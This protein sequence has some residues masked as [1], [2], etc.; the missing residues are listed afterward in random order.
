MA[1]NVKNLIL[2]RYQPLRQA[3][4]GGFASVVVAFDT[5]IQRTVALK[6]IKLSASEEARAALPG[7]NAV[8]PDPDLNLPLRG[9]HIKQ[10]AAPL[11]GQG[12]SYRSPHRRPVSADK[13]PLTPDTVAWETADTVALEDI[14]P[15]EDEPQREQKPGADTSYDGVPTTA[16][17]RRLEPNSPALAHA[18]EA[19]MGAGSEDIESRPPLMTHLPGLD[20]ART[21]AML[22]DPSIVTVYDFEVRDGYAYLIMEYIEGLT[23]A[24]LLYS[25]HDEITLDM[26]T[27]VFQGVARALQVA[28]ERSVLHLDVKPDN[29]L[30]TKKGQVK[31]T[32]FGLATLADASGAANPGGGTIAY[33]P[34]EQLQRQPVDARS[35]EW[36]LASLT[37]EMFSGEQPFDA[38]SFDEAK[39]KIQDAELLLPSLCW[40]DLPEE[41]D[42]VMFRALAIDRE[43]RYETV[44]KFSD[45]LMPYL[46][47][48]KTGVKELKGIVS[49]KDPGIPLE[50]AISRQ[51][52][53]LP[54]LRERITLGHRRAGARAV[55][56]AGTALLFLLVAV[57]FSHVA[58]WG[59]SGVAME[60]VAA[61]GGA[62]LGAVFPRFGTLVGYGLLSLTF[63]L[64]NS[65]ATGA[66]LLVSTALWWYHIGR[67]DA[68]S[69]NA[70]LAFP[71]VG[72]C[73]L[74]PLT[75]LIAGMVEHPLR[76][77]GT[78]A[79]SLV[80]ALSLV[81]SWTSGVANDLLVNLVAWPVVHSLVYGIPAVAQ[82]SLLGIL[83]QPAFWVTCAS[84]LVAAFV[85]AVFRNWQGRGYAYVGAI[86]ATVVL[87][88]GAVVGAVVSQ[89]SVTAPPIVSACMAGCIMLFVSSLIPD[90][91]EEGALPPEEE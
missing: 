90:E 22:N 60:V 81:G 66:V 37:Y 83:T 15:W 55:S 49:S 19:T 63:L 69:S 26:I 56:A 78:T 39:E 34:L 76:A 72:A 62:L 41:A 12:G 2:D 67:E 52:E 28:H 24:E 32:D 5:R 86:F 36:A 8:A 48:A 61:L 88:V 31:V 80:I 23:L 54:P 13:L 84:W 50:E 4:Q 59:F 16:L 57:T 53:P 25:Y 33:M 82:P 68:T 79:Y 6:I 47:N 42:D 89:V 87:V 18:I 35:D 17:S 1:S 91:A 75:P 14:P 77:V 11:R 85:F 10:E 20:E 40:E 38:E 65:P 7:A 21:A 64:N 3:G 51:R 9:A 45:E 44:Q 70:G 30:I 74:G 43:N 27:A 73:W 71:L 29:V 58:N 46:G